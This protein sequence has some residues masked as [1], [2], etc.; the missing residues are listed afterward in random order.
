M[1]LQHDILP[2]FDYRLA[3]TCWANGSFEVIP[4]FRSAEQLES[5][6]TINEA[7]TNDSVG[8]KM[9]WQGDT[10]VVLPGGNVHQTDFIQ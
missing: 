10:M 6:S 1:R 4:S 9:L 5:A 8:K 2:D 3:L 7:D